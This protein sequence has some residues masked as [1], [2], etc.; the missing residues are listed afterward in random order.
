MFNQMKRSSKHTY[1]FQGDFLNADIHKLH[2]WQHSLHESWPLYPFAAEESMRH[3]VIHFQEH[4]CRYLILVFLVDGKL[5][6]HFDETEFDLRKG[7]ALLIPPGSSYSFETQENGFYYKKVLEIKGVNLLSILETLGLNKYEHFRL[8]ENIDWFLQKLTVIT[9][10]IERNNPADFS[11]LMGTTYTL[12]NEF[13]MLKKRQKNTTPR[14]L[15]AIQT[16]L[17]NQLNESLSI[18]GIAEEFHI[19]QTYLESLFRKKFGISP[20]EYRINCKIEQAK[21]L[22]HHT[23]LSM[24]EIA[25]QTGYCNQFY[26]SQEFKRMT[27]ETPSLFRRTQSS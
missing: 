25:F 19:S 4:F 9:D 5:R 3:Q 20:R 17:E 14:L 2:I 10:L 13:S 26:F 16:R 11:E 27:G 6:Y 7:D 23:N 15:T 21:Y 18:R 1:S 12:L 22:L 24:K 8:K